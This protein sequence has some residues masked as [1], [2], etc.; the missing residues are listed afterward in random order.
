MLYAYAKLEV[1]HV[2]VCIYIYILTHEFKCIFHVHVLEDLTCTDRY[3]IYIVEK[4]IFLNYWL[5]LEFVEFSLGFFVYVFVTLNVM[6]MRDQSLTTV[7]SEQ[8][9]LNETNGSANPEYSTNQSQMQLIKN[10]SNMLMVFLMELFSF[11]AC[12]FIDG[13]IIELINHT[14]TFTRVSWKNSITVEL[15]KYLRLV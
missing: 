13:R 10:A 3:K 6:C 15:L 1:V 11:R 4:L 2:C 9:T 8:L 14:C 5:F 12:T 7:T